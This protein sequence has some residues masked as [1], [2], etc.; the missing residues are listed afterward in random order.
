MK[1]YLIIILIVVSAYFAV[2]R[3]FLAWREFHARYEPD[4]KVAMLSILGFIIGA[5]AWPVILV[6]M[7]IDWYKEKR[8]K[9]RYLILAHS[10][11]SN[12]FYTYGYIMPWWY[13]KR[14][15]KTCKLF[16][17][18]EDNVDKIQFRVITEEEYIE[19]YKPIPNFTEYG[20]LLGEDFVRCYSR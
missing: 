16:N 1:T 18:D 5:V 6:V 19:R 14:L 10:R 20:T 4:Y 15:K 9:H 17:Q 12:E 11:I 3:A 13:K 8:L 2:T 7:G